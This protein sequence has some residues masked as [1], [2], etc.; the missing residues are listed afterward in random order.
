MFEKLKSLIKAEPS[1]ETVKRE[2][3]LVRGVRAVL[4]P[5]RGVSP[6]DWR[7]I[8]SVTHPNGVETCTA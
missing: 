7:P 4:R 1:T 6:E 2:S 3:V 5:R 8:A